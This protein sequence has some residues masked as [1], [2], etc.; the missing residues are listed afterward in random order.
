MKR[1]RAILIAGPTAAGK[2]ALALDLA[3]RHGG[4]VVNADSMQV[5][6]ELRILTARPND[7]D[8]ADVPHALYGH[9]K[10]ADVY[11]VGRWL[12]D[13]A[14]VLEAAS[15]EDRLAVV[16]GGTGLYFKALLEGLSPIPEVPAPVRAR[17][18]EKARE[19][20]ARGLHAELGRRDPAMAERLRPT[21]TQRLTRALEVHDATGCSLAVWQMMSANP[22][23]SEVETQRFVLAP[24]RSE[25]KLRTDAR[26][27]RMISAGAMDEVRRLAA[28]ELSPDLPAMRAVGVRPLLAAVEGRSSLEEA[29][30]RAK[31]DTGQ[32]IKRQETWLKRHMIAW[33]WNP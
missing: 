4:I 17:W 3:R 5:Y 30:A 26:L 22:L 27:E 16:V 11:S 20:G 9:V 28:L 15:K 1:V 7:A 2:S 23:L 24:E 32:Y 13:A 21:D 6:S 14:A 12:A 31:L 19:I 10:A 29:I 8:M 18:R 25:L 33:K